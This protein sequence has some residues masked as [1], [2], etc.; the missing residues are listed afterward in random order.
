MKKQPK[1]STE[2]PSDRVGENFRL[3]GFDPDQQDSGWQE[4]P[5]FFL[6]QQSDGIGEYRVVP[7]N[8]T[9]TIRAI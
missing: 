5:R 1:R 9:A 8:G 6:G 7:S 4:K 2:K 3:F